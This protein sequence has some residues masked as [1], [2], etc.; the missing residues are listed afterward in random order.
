MANYTTNI[1][2]GKLIPV[3]T[4]TERNAL[5]GLSSG[6]TIFNITT[7][8]FEIYNGSSWYYYVNSEGM[9]GGQ[10]I[11]GGTGSGDD[12]DI[13]ASSNATQG[14]INLNS[15]VN[16]SNETTI[17]IVDTTNSEALTINQ[18]DV[19]NGP[20]AVVIN[21]TGNG[22]SLVI[23]TNEFVVENDGTLSV[24]GVSNY[25]TLVTDDDDLPNK[26]YVDDK[27][28]DTAY[29]ATSWDSV[30][31]IAPTKNAVRDKFVTN[32]AAISL[33]TTHRTSDGTDHTYIDQDLQTSASPTFTGLTVTNEIT[34]NGG[35]DVAS[36]NDYQIDNTSVLNATTLGA[37][38][39]NSSLTSVGTLTDLTVTNEIA[40]NGGIDVASG[41][42]YQIDN[43]TVL[44]ATTLGANVV[45][46]S[47]TN[48]Y[49]NSFTVDSDNATGK[50]KIQT[51]TG[52]TDNTVTL[53][54]T[55]TTGDVTIT[56]P[57][58]SG[59]V[60]LEE[61]TNVFT[62]EQTITIADTTNS[63]ALTINQNDT[64]NNPVAVVINNTG[65]GDSLNINS[66]E[67]KVESDGT[68]SVSGVTDYELLLTND[69]DIPNKKYVDDIFSV[70]SDPTGFDAENQTTCPDVTITESSRTITADVQGG[71]TEF[72][73][74]I[75]GIRYTKTSADS[76]VFPNTTGI[77]VI[78]YDGL[79]LSCDDT[80]TE[81]ETAIIIRNYPIVAF[82]Y[83]DSLKGEAIYFTGNNERH[84]LQMDGN[85]HAYLHFTQK[86]K[87]IEGLGLANFNV[88]DNGDSDEDAQFSCADGIIQDEDIAIGIYDDSPQDLS[89][90]LQAA[91]LYRDG[92]SGLW[93][94][95]Y[96]P[97]DWAADTA[98][99]TG[100][101][102]KALTGN[103]STRGLIFECTVAGT[104][105]ST[106]PTWQDDGGAVSADGGDPC[107][108]TTTDNTATWTCVGSYHSAV[109][110]YVGGDYRAAYNEWTGA[111]WQQTE[112]TNGDFLLAH[113]VATNDSRHPII[114]LQGL[115]EYG[116]IA[117]AREGATNEITQI[118]QSGLPFQEF[119]FLGTVIFR[120]NNGYDN[121]SKCA[122]ISTD[123]GG[124]YVN[125]LT[126]SPQGISTT[127][128]D[129]GNLS[130]LTD[131]DHAQYVNF[132]NRSIT[133]VA[134]AT[135]DITESDYILNVTYTGTGAVTSLTL[136]SAQTLEGRMLIIKDAGGN[137][138][139]N[140]ITIDTE[141]SETIDGQATNV[142]STDY[143]VVRLYSDGTNWFVI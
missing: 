1:K 103:A 61:L 87:H 80:P 127:F 42:D 84:G 18:N 41:N 67:F 58:A 122:I 123:E 8:R 39:V 121:H 94:K 126:S 28:D 51:T 19:T 124:D 74:Y 141:A 12:L 73:Y 63:E 55:A 98:Y 60:T 134:T 23:N 57:D 17:T 133:T 128:Q 37:N 40:A 97:E 132:K 70:M 69:D 140:N 107:G 30:T 117:L 27:V 43:T 25:E 16:I 110:N 71:E 120:T 135:Y 77:K 64:T 78:Y 47:L 65:T 118:Q 53:T 54:N 95:D 36:G 3:L 85:T 102:V 44:D 138:N 99:S 109:K 29:N 6:E 101:R 75:D 14:D 52:G 5:S 92:A 38:V 34:A 50:L 2:T 116:N 83:W 82:I 66:G 68:L 33:N 88:D 113:I 81:G 46:S 136:T 48:T 129:H 9:S 115:N 96:I 105:D 111:T 24:A 22:D 143:G 106:E 59:T 142:I 137:A 10:T 91:I 108:A 7:D 15:T 31:T 139:T 89:T 100:D 112:V 119:V 4:T 62:K 49:A 21:N 114:A 86:A 13:Y 131:D 72:Y 26:K 56:L 20:D 79:T 45:N 90:I 93:K 125:F 104:S 11:Y 35:I 76:V 32:D 130:G